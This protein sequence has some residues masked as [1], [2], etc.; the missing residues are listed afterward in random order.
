MNDMYRA[1]EV[2][3]ELQTLTASSYTWLPAVSAG[4][5]GQPEAT[6]RVK[7]PM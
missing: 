3:Q 6:K 1:K 2:A 7:G 4:V 5:T